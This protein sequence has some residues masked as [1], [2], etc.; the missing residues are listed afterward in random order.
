MFHDISDTLVLLESR[1]SPHYR[2]FKGP[3]LFPFR[4]KDMNC[5]IWSGMRSRAKVLIPFWIWSLYILRRINERSLDLS[6]K[7]CF[8]KAFCTTIGFIDFGLSHSTATFVK[9]LTSLSWAL[10][11]HWGLSWEVSSS[12]FWAYLCGWAH[13]LQVFFMC[14]LNI[15][16]NI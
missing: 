15:Y 7:L 6:S 13:Y 3:W 8:H 2:L 9:T 4:G 16:E 5:W 10:C 11:Y 12:F 1:L 14:Q